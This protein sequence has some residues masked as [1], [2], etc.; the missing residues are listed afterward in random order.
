[1][2]EFIRLCFALDSCTVGK[3][4]Y[5]GGN[6]IGSCCPGD[7]LASFML[8]PAPGASR[9]LGEPIE[10]RNLPHYLTHSKEEAIQ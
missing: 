3:V 2:T 7:D 4:E 9:A 5:N 1:M 6:L 10:R 8:E